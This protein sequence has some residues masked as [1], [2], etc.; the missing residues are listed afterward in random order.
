MGHNARGALAALAAFGIFA[1]H[2]VVVKF[3]GGTYSPVQIIFFSVLLSF[4]LATVMLLRDETPDTLIPRNPGWVL[5]RT[6]AA[7]VTALCAFYAFSVLPLAQ[8]YAILFAAPLIITVLSVPIL[9]ETVRLRRWAAVI[10]GLAGVLIVLRPGTTPLGLGHLAALTAAVGGALASV[11]VRKIA[12]GE[13]A[14]VIL[15]YPMV[16]NFLVMG[17]ALPLVYEPMPL[18]D[19]GALAVMALLAWTAT[20]ML[21]AAYTMADAVVVAPMQYSQILW[22]AVYGLIFFDETLDRWTGIGA[23]VIIASGLFILYR[24]GR[25]GTSANRPNLSTRSRV[26]TPAVPRVSG[27]MGLARRATAPLAKPPATE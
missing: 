13:R 14:A 21:I 10:V 4:P 23:A 6:V 12:G 8:V 20:R 2:D 7:V 26:G 27:L 24:E 11:I 17:A 5:V 9:G 15:L 3:L 25:T 1:T 22:A 16:A 18:R 19:F